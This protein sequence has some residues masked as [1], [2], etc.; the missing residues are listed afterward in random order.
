MSLDLNNPES[1]K[2]QLTEELQG[3]IKKFIK[4]SIDNKQTLVTLG[5]SFILAFKSY[6]EHIKSGG[7]SEIGQTERIYFESL[8]NILT[9]VITEDPNTLEDLM[10]IALVALKKA[11]KDIFDKVTLNEAID[12]IVNGLVRDIESK[13]KVTKLKEEATAIGIQA[14]EFGSVVDLS[15]MESLVKKLRKLGDSESYRSE[16]YSRHMVGMPAIRIINFHPSIQ[17]VFL[18]NDLSTFLANI[19]DAFTIPSMSSYIWHIDSFH[20]F[21]EQAE[22]FENDLRNFLGNPFPTDIE[23]AHKNTRKF[24]DLVRVFSKYKEQITALRSHPSGLKAIHDYI[25]RE[26]LGSLADRS[27][28]LVTGERFTTGSWYRTYETRQYLNT[29]E[30]KRSAENDE[31]KLI[32][33]AREL[34]VSHAKPTVREN[35]LL[36]L[37]IHLEKFIAAYKGHPEQ[38]EIALRRGIFNYYTDSANFLIGVY[39]F[40]KN[41]VHAFPIKT[42]LREALFKYITWRV[43]FL[44]KQIE[45]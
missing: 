5:T 26:A 10:N 43:Q 34:V 36:Q 28:Q 25:L 15:G 33:Q 8:N 23:Q 35:F 6:L 18:L 14:D 19:L 44:K 21:L 16:G 41:N 22:L 31:N 11:C 12:Q 30:A 40:L 4:P 45:G 20:S 42:E 2:S 37:D 13:R 7:Q 29:V 32:L 9:Q 39:D 1:L 3:I 27:E 38:M 24:P 17:D